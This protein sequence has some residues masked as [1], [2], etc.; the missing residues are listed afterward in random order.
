MGKLVEKNEVASLKNELLCT[1]IQNHGVGLKAGF[2]S[3][4]KEDAAD[5]RWATL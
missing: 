4:H 5:R 3:R 1:C 2:W